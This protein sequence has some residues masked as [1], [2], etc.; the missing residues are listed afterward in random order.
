MT[1]TGLDR[2]LVSRKLFI[3]GDLAAY[4]DITCQMV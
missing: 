4:P 1:E 3:T 2:K